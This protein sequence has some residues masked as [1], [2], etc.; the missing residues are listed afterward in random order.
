MGRGAECDLVVPD[1]QSSR[2]HASIEAYGDRWM[3]RDLGSANGTFLN[4]QRLESRQPLRSGDLIYVGQS[5]LMF[6]Q[7]PGA[8][9]QPPPPGQRPARR[10]RSVIAVILGVAVVLLTLASAGAILLTMEPVESAEGGGLPG[11]PDIGIPTIDLGTG[12]PTL[13]LPI[14]MPTGMPSL[15][16]DIIPL[17]TGGIQIPTV[18]L[19]GFGGGSP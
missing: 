14:E 12:I 11:L 15:P 18:S 10:R 16:T 9:P 17:P 3:I 1:S 13:D 19:P 8:S 4:R 6:D 2:Q 7:R 5:P